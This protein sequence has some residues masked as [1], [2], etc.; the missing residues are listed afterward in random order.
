MKGILLVNMGGP[1]SQKEMKFFLKNMFCD[2]TILPFPK[3]LRF[4]ISTL[5]STLRYKKSWNKYLEIGGTP[6]VKDTEELAKQTNVIFGE[7]Y[8]VVH[9][10]SYSRPLIKDVLKALNKQEI[11]DVTV[12]PLYPHYSFSTWQSVVNDSEESK[13]DGLLSFVNPFYKNEKYIEFF[14]QAITESL[15][16]NNF[17]KPT[18][19]FSAHSIP[20]KLIEKGDYYESDIRNSAKLI[21]D[22]LEL[23]FLVSF[24]SQIGKKWLG[25]ITK[26]VIKEFDDNSSKELLIVPISFVGENLETLYDIE[27]IIIPDA[28]KH[29]SLKIARMEFSKNQELL[30]LAIVDEIRKI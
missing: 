1:Q 5:I 27:K 17:T 12:V 18:L 22:K 26:N 25:P 13:F 29:T 6:I 20:N 4:L 8:K 11:T 16:K 23:P 7:D 2:K 9:A 21:A 10:F 15:D 28:K 30:S 24:Q 3:F 14:A 19:L